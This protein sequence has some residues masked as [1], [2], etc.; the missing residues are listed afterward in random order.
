[1]P[2]S[3][4]AANLAAIKAT[5]VINGVHFGWNVALAGLADE[6][7]FRVFC[8]VDGVKSNEVGWEMLTNENIPVGIFLHDWRILLGNNLVI[9]P[10]LIT[11]K[12]ASLRDRLLREGK[13]ELLLDPT[14]SPTIADGWCVES[15][16]SFL[17]LAEGAVN[18]TQVSNTHYEESG[19]GINITRRLRQVYRFDT[20]VI[21]H[22]TPGA[23]A[24]LK[25][26][27]AGGFIGNITQTVGPPALGVGAGCKAAFPYYD[28]YG[29]DPTNISST[30]WSLGDAAITAGWKP[31]GENPPLITL[32][33]G[34]GNPRS[35]VYDI[36]SSLIS[37]ADDFAAYLE[38]D[39]ADAQGHSV[40]DNTQV[41]SNLSNV[42]LEIEAGYVYTTDTAEASGSPG[43]CSKASCFVSKSVSASLATGTVGNNTKALPSK[44]TY[45][46]TVE[47]EGSIG[48]NTRA[49]VTKQAYV[50]AA[51]VA[52]SVGSNTKVA[53]CIPVVVSATKVIGSYGSV[54]KISVIKYGVVWTNTTT[55]SPGTCSRIRVTVL[56][57]S[58]GGCIIG[59]TVVGN[60]IVRS[61]V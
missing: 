31:V 61:C 19:G 29:W 51:N 52:G 33:A 40:D 49:S 60:S 43:G 8:F 45:V 15:Q 46:P 11:L 6:L 35:L 5:Q 30:I 22:I 16:D 26:D 14:V 3:A 39:D 38:E 20:T 56:S 21:N 17:G 12:M 1:M 23:Q 44:Q 42:V 53:A 9:A 57:Q 50:S 36:D 18:H 4:T 13:T 27:W 34:T 54:C 58:H 48:S 7:T 55:G 28:T 59:S 37:K 41:Y 24:K 2:S 32:E 25:L 10:P 47:V